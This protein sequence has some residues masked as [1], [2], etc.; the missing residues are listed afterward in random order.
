MT[1]RQFS[2][3]PRWQ[4]ADLGGRAREGEIL[5]QYPGGIGSSLGQLADLRDGQIVGR[6]ARH[7]VQV[8]VVQADQPGGGMQIPASR[9]R[10]TNLS[11]V[12]LQG[13]DSARRRADGEIES[14]PLCLKY[15]GGHLSYGGI[16]GRGGRY[17]G[18]LAEGARDL[19]L[20]AAQHGLIGLQKSRRAYAGIQHVV[21]CAL[22]AAQ[23][24]PV[25]PVQVVRGNHLGRTPREL[26]L[27]G[28]SLGPAGRITERDQSAE[29]SGQARIGYGSGPSRSCCA[30]LVRPRS[31]PADWPVLQKW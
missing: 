14:V 8:V 6:C 23:Q 5:A 31:G 16:T 29:T 21:N 27:A 28:P 13:A 10:G 1:P 3:G 9:I 15:G 19:P 7:E 24:G 18:H 25:I 4:R 20:M 30:H 26:P 22:R 11:R 17:L 2:A 12:L